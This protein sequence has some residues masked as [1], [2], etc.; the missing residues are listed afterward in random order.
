MIHG[1]LFLDLETDSL[2]VD[3]AEIKFVGCMDADGKSWMKEWN[4]KTREE[5]RDKIDLASKVITFNGEAYDLPILKRFGIA[6]P[7]WSHIDL[8]EV[9]KKR[10]PL[11]RSG[12]FKSYSLKNLVKEIGVETEGKGTIDYKVFQKLK[13]TAKEYED[14]YKYLEQDLV[15]TKELWDYLVEK[16]DNL[17]GFLN[18]KDVKNYKHIT[19]STGAYAY[20]VICNELGLKEEYEDGDEHTKYE[21]AFVMTPT[22][23]SARGDILYLDFASLYP[24]LYVHANLFSSKCE[25]CTKEE[26]W[27]GND[28]FQVNGY[29]CKKKQ[30]KIEN[31]VKKFYLQRKEYKKA[32]DPRQFAIKIILNTLYGVSSRKTFKHLYS[33]Y[34]ASDCTSLARQ[35]IE[36]TIKTLRENGYIPI[37]GDTDSVIVDINGKSKQ[38]CL[39]LA[40][41]ISKDISNALPFSWEEFNLKL[42]DELVYIQF[43]RGK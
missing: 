13:W 31:L 43:F 12:G 29:Y 35:C 26:K 19:S 37:Y 20:K 39:D 15:V 8:Y 11:I 42:E 14:I 3:E 5:L 30:G 25:C 36:Y 21:G 27:N 33:K 10:A 38:E 1:I 4:D 24:M 28:M 16:F 23:D 6:V 40:Q 18:E 9:Y 2:D 41:K 34:T 32:K 7:Y 22:V 17:K